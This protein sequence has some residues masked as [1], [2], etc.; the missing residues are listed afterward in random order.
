MTTEGYQHEDRGRDRDW[1]AEGSFEDQLWLRAVYG[2]I[3]VL[4]ITGNVLVVFTVARVPSLRSLTNMF[5]V[6]LAVCDFLTSV[7]LIPLHLGIVIPVPPGLT[8]DLLCRLLLSK[9]P[10]WTSFIASVLTLTCVTLERYFSIVHPFRYKIMRNLQKNALAMRQ[11]ASTV[12]RENQLSRDLL[13]ARKKVIKMLLTVVVTFAICWAPNQLMFFAYMCGWNLDFS[14]WY[15]HASVLIAFCNSCMNPFIYGFQ[16]KQYRKALKKA[17]GR[18]NAVG[19][20]A[21]SSIA[22]GG[23]TGIRDHHANRQNSVCPRGTINKIPSVANKIE[24]GSPV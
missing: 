4:G 9:F 10:L 11:S 12:G 22:F 23:T 5:I 16:S 15:Y 20:N 19:V 13:N 2:V 8:G 24:L 6:S 14:S 21:E 1:S 7:F 3:A 17:L 18:K